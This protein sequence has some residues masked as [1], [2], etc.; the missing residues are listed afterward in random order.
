MNLLDWIGRSEQASDIATATPHAALSATFDRPAER[1]ADG[2]TYH[3]GAR[4]HAGW[5][6]MQASAVIG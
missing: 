5:L 1:P 3:L 2:K 6:T 4:A